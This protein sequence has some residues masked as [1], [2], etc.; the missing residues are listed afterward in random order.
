MIVRVFLNLLIIYILLIIPI[1]PIILILIQRERP[2][3]RPRLS[4]SSRAAGA[5][6]CPALS[7][8]ASRRRAPLRWAAGCACCG[9]RLLPSWLQLRSWPASRSMGGVYS[10]HPWEPGGDA[11]TGF[12]RT[13]SVIPSCDPVSRSRSRAL[14]VKSLTI[15]SPQ[16]QWQ[17]VSCEWPND[18][19]HK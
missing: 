14:L 16:S 15:E 3:I 2:R 8:P 1:I 17:C 7:S 10:E 4:C 18:M 9:S 6:S 11:L 13:L 5:S 19:I 12:N